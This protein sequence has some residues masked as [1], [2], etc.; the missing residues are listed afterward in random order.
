MK[1]FYFFLQ[2][3]IILV[4]NP[5]NAQD[6]PEWHSIKMDK[7]GFSASFYQPPTVSTLHEGEGTYYNFENIVNEKEHPNKLYRI[8]V[9]DFSDSTD[10]IVQSKEA[11]LITLKLHSQGLQLIDKSTMTRGRILLNAY[12]LQSNNGEYIR[13]FIGNGKKKI[14]TIEVIC[15]EEDKFNVD[16]IKFMQNFNI[17][18]YADQI[19]SFSNDSLSYTMNFLFTP[20]TQKIYS[21]KENIE[22]CTDVYGK[23]P[24]KQEEDGQFEGL[25]KVIIERSI[26]PIEAYTISET[27]YYPD[28]MPEEIPT[29]Q[30]NDIRKEMI[31]MV[32][33]ITPEGKFLKEEELKGNPEGIAFTYT[34]LDNRGE[35]RTFLCRLFYTKHTLYTLRVLLR[36]KD[37]ANHPDVINFLDSFRIK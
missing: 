32:V 19:K 23:A 12:S 3:F 24:K 36:H 14:Y 5:L 37:E 2:T 26:S 33:H 6:T 22:Y 30:K 4:T 16:V 34:G 15:K 1:Q 9:W 10:S 35:H 17:N 31:H 7:L 27:H 18:L 8:S 11:E 13:F 28:Q 20:E 25:K 29:E 21:P